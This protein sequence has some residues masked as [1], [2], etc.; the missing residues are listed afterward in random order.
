VMIF[1]FPSSWPHAQ[2]FRQSPA[3][4]VQARRSLIFSTLRR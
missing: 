3:T 2:N 4:R 1:L